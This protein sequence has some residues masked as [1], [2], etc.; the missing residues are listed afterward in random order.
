MA[1]ARDRDVNL[2]ISDSKLHELLTPQ[3]QLLAE[4]RR[5]LCEYGICTLSSSL[6]VY[7]N[8]SRLRHIIFLEQL[9]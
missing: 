9:D 1:G 3:V 2:I 5:D 8:V 4:Q 6:Q 7:L